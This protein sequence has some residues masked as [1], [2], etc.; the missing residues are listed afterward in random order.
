MS[1]HIQ[2]TELQLAIDAALQIA[3]EAGKWAGQAELE[4]FYD[5]E[6][7]AISALE[8]LYAKK[9]AMPLQ[10]ACNGRTVV[11]NLRSEEWR[12]GVNNSA[13]KYLEK[14]KT[15]IHIAISDL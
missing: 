8:S 13:N 1:Q 15:I 11:V 9:N 10:E 5:K 6:Q 4:Q 14:A 7:F 2:E 3:F 12:K